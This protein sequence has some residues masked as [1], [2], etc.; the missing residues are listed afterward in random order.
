MNWLSRQARRL[1]SARFLGAGL[2]LVLL[3]LR[4]TDPPPLE[5]LRLRAFD[6]FQRISPRVVTQRPVVIVD[7]DEKSLSKLGQWPWARTR[8]AELINKLNAA[9]A[10]AIGFDIVFAEPDRLSPALAADGF[11]GVDE[12][13]RNKLRSLPSND[14]VM[15]EAL[16]H[17]KT[18]LG[19]TGVSE[20]T[21]QPEGVPQVAG[22]AWI[23]TDP[24]PFLIKY[25]GLLR[26]TAELEKAAFGRGMFSI[27][28]ERDGIIRRV[29]MVILA[30][31][32][33]V[34]SLTFEM[35]RLVTASDSA[36]IRADPF[37]ITTVAV[38]GLVVPTDAKGRLWIYF[39][40]HDPGRYVS[41]VDVLEGRFPADRFAQRLVLI[42]TSAAG[43]LDTKTTPVSPVIP[44]VEIHAQIVENLL[45]NA[46]LSA[47]NYS[48]YVEVLS[49]FV[50][51]VALVYRDTV[52]EPRAEKR[53]KDKTEW[54]LGASLRA[55]GVSSARRPSMT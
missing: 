42:G 8:V 36:L 16:R 49:A 40:P 23:G 27:E 54:L 2:L 29:P 45:T 26:N 51:G 43:L 17:S 4:L 50:L 46:M 34:T 35:L 10:A 48:I 24:T 3:A 37:G 22:T 13:T 55:A 28:Q 19:I 6:I 1:A 25:P 12:E 38:P 7:I 44:G 53:L 9:G 21:P 31:G 20:P 32:N 39:S 30:Q 15:A 14:Q 47:P 33:R 41:A 18:V 52:S 5:D 11:R